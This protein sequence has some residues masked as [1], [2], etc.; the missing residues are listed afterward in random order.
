MVTHY[1]MQ[2]IT[3]QGE[4]L[5]LEMTTE[6]KTFE[7]Y[8]NDTMSNK[9][10]ISHEG[11]LL[12]TQDIAEMTL[13]EEIHDGPGRYHGVGLS[14][15]SPKTRETKTRSS[16]SAKKPKTSAESKSR[17]TSRDVDLRDIDLDKVFA[18]VELVSI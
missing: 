3:K 13:I 4:V 5:E 11:G 16:S 14:F 6:G 7:K 15:N 12:D 17:S 1:K 8:R 2:V 18:G 10:M 9:W